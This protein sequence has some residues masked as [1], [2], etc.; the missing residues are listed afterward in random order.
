VQEFK[1]S[2]YRL[3]WKKY[4]GRSYCKDLDVDEDV[5]VGGMG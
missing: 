4:K 3:W 2:A 1:R 5:D